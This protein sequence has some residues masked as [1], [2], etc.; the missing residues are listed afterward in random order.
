VAG[1]GSATGDLGAVGLEDRD[2][3]LRRLGV[4][5]ADQPEPENGAGLGEADAHVA[6]AGLD[7]HRVRP[8]LAAAHRL[9]EDLDRRPV[10]D[11]AAR[12]ERLQLAIE[13]ERKIGIDPLEPHQR[14]V[15]NGRQHTPAAAR[16][17]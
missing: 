8:D 9:L 15:A 17:V 1:S 5:H 7:D 11:A 16:L 13:L 14:R 4:H 2:V 12:V 6:R 10:L 3:L